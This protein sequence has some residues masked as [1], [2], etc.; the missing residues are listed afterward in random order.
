VISP[1]YYGTTSLPCQTTDYS[2]L[3]ISLIKLRSDL[4][5]YSYKDFL[6]RFA[7]LSPWI[8]IL[9]VCLAFLIVL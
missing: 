6:T 8:Y 4:L 3:I 2:L 1:S 9:I 5:V 7:E